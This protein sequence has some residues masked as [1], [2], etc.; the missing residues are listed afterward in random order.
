METLGH[1]TITV[2]MNAWS[3]VIPALQRDGADRMP[4]ILAG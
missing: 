2:T 3:H 4:E 1:S